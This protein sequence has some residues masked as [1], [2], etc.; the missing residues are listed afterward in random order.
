MQVSIVICLKLVQWQ[1]FIQGVSRL[2]KRIFSKQSSAI[3]RSARPIRSMSLMALSCFDLQLA[4][5]GTLCMRFKLKTDHG[6][7]VHISDGCHH[8]E[9]GGAPPQSRG[10]GI[11]SEIYPVQGFVPL[12]AFQVSIWT[13]LLGN[14]RIFPVHR[15]FWRKLMSELNFSIKAIDFR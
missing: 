9:V 6:A 12:P 8:Q 3:V 4:Y 14:Q 11:S 13:S 10:G 7:T 2:V 5:R 1:G 15:K